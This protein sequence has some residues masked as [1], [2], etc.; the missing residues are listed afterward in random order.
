MAKNYTYAVARARALEARMLNSVQLSRMLEASDA[1]K[2]FFVLNETSYG[3]HISGSD[4]PF[5]Y[6]GIVNSE[7]KFVYDFL[8]TYASNDPSFNILL[9]RYDYGNAKLLIRSSKI[10]DGNTA[11]GLSDFGTIDK[12]ELGTYIMKGIGRVPGWMEVAVGQALLAFEEESKPSAID[13]IL[14]AAY[15]TDLKKSVEPLLV[16][17]SKVMGETSYAVDLESDN[18]VIEL[19]RAVRRR[20]FGIAPLIAFWM[21]KEL[22]AKTIKIILSAKKHRVT[23]E[24]IKGYMRNN[25]V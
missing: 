7:L 18:K 2:G 11:E 8:M 10:K 12:E 24:M 6:E 20:S 21:A 17:I 22:E 3:D 23:T 1:E 25:Y 14:D 5:G 13:D 19:L 15:I 4:Q 16:N 9:R